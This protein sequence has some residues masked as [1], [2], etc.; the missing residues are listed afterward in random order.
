MSECLLYYLKEGTT[1]VGRVGDIQLS[2][3]FILDH[4]CSFVHEKGQYFVKIL[5]CICTY[6]LYPLQSTCTYTCDILL[7]L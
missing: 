4:H 6:K 7:S 1:L 5:S 2:G 3:D